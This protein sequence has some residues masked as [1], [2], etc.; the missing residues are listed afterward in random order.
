MFFRVAHRIVVFALAASTPFLAT[1]TAGVFASKAVTLQ[2]AGS[3]PKGVTA[4]CGIEMLTNTQGVDFNPYIRDVYLSVKKSWYAGMPPSVVKGQQG[5]NAL[6]FRILQDGNIPK[7]FPKITSSSGKND[8]DAASVQAI[9]G[10][11]PFAHLPDKFSQ[12]FV[13]LRFTFYYNVPIP[14]GPSR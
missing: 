1:Q 13:T 14:P 12:P 11:A 9:R 5:V 8:L 10:A 4:A 6:E 7:D 2:S 3:L